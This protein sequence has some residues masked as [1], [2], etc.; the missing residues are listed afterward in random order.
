M[1]TLMN[2]ITWFGEERELVLVMQRMVLQHR[3]SECAE[4][5]QIESAGLAPEADSCT[6]LLAAHAGEEV[7]HGDAEQWVLGVAEMEDLVPVKLVTRRRG[8]RWGWGEIHVRGHRTGASGAKISW[9]LDHKKSV[10]I[11]VCRCC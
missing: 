4:V 6:V 5:V 1:V 11:I 9:L 3:G 2:L 8:K 10:H 7:G